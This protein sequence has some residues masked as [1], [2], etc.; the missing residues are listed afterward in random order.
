MKLL[1]QQFYNQFKDFED[2]VNKSKRNKKRMLN[3]MKYGFIIAGSFMLVG[4]AVFMAIPDVLIKIFS[5][6]DNMVEIASYAYRIIAL[7]FLLA[8]IC[9]ICGSLFQAIGRAFYSMI[10]SIARQLVVLVPAAWI[11]SVVGG[12]YV[13]WWCFPLAELMSLTISLI[14]MKHVK[15]TVLDVM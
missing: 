2:T 8:W 12:L 14:W 11:L 9:I 6:N 15:K 3:T 13:I 7:H 4:C 10:V 5:A 1:M